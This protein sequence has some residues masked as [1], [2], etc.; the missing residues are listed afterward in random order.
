MNSTPFEQPKKSNRNMIII[1]VVVVLLCC[2]CCLIIVGARTY[3]Q[4]Q[5]GGIFD[6]IN[7]QLNLT[8]GANNSNPLGGNPSVATAEAM[9]T[10]VAK[11]TLI[12]DGMPTMPAIA[13]PTVE[14]M[15]T[16]VVPSTDLNKAIPQGGLGN[17]IVRATAWGYV[18][19]AAAMNGCNAS[20]P[21]KTSIEVTQKPASSTS[22]WAE[23][24]TVTCMDGS[25]A[26]FDVSYVPDATGATVSVSSSK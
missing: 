1:I 19:T 7:Q 11:G 24:W 15:P 4:S 25:K 14:G 9:A 13:V 26:A 18:L 3:M 10:A 12:P 23:K 22:P 6:S 8:P 5:V 20:D 21:T 17:D 2:C 16:V